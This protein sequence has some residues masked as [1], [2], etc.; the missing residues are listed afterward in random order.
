MSLK[1]L[2]AATPQDSA[3]RRGAVEKEKEKRREELTA[4]S[5][6]PGGV[7]ELGAGLGKGGIGNQEDQGGKAHGAAAVSYRGLS[8]RVHVRQGTPVPRPV[9]LL[10]PRV[11]AL[12]LTSALRS[13][14][15]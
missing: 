4:P 1:S 2:R 6:A 12:R 11:A 3:A 15:Y 8:L 10:P 14:S 7:G 9:H 5:A 13:G